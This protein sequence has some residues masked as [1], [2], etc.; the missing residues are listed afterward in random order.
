LTGKSTNWF[1]SG[2]G[3]GETKMIEYCEGKSK[4]SE[5]EIVQQ[6]R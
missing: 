3:R 6:G 1:V 2:E 4:V 5:F